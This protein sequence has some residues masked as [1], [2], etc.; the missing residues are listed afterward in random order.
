M[1]HENWNLCSL[2]YPH[3][4]LN[5]WIITVLDTFSS[6]NLESNKAVKQQGFGYK[7][8]IFKNHYKTIQDLEVYL[9][10]LCKSASKETWKTFTS[11]QNY[12]NV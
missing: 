10:Y 3:L 11:N 8:I 12:W 7:V 9:F 1:F 4:I 6:Q 2:L 5:Y